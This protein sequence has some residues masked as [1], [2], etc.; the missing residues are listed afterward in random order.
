MS[1]LIHPNDIY[2]LK[3][4]FVNAKAYVLDFSAV[5]CGP[6]KILGA[7]LES[8]ADQYPNVSIV[9]IDIDNENFKPFLDMLKE[10][11]KITINSIPRLLFYKSNKLVND[12]TGLKLNDIKAGLELLNKN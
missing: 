4:I 11:Q 2:E 12:I 8:M 6:C 1:K 10:K 9:K 3:D 5:W 7:K